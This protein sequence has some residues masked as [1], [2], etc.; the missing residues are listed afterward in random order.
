MYRKFMEILATVAKDVA[1]WNIDIEEAVLKFNDTKIDICELREELFNFEDMG[2][3][4]REE[5]DTLK[6]ILVYLYI[7]NS[8]LDAETIYSLIFSRGKKITW[9]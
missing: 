5:A 7:R 4:D 8:D 1:D 2:F 9:H 3:L 6:N